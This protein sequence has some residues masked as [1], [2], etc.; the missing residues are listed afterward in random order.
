MGIVNNE[1]EIAKFL[2]TE[3][4]MVVARGSGGGE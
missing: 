2:E 3:R 4:R 1:K